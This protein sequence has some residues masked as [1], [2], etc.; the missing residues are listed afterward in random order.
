MRIGSLAAKFGFMIL[1]AQGV[2]AEAAEVKVLSALAMSPVMNE[3]GPQFERATGHN[4]VIQFDVA[5]LTTSLIDDLVKQGKIAAGTRAN[6]ARSGLGVIVRT[7][8]P[9]P[10]ISSA[11]AF[12][13]TMLDAKSISYGK[14]GATAIY[15]PGLFERLGIAEQMKSKTKHSGAQSVADGEAELGLI[16]ISAFQPVPGAELLGPFPPA[17][18][19]YVGYTG[20]VATAAKEADAGKALLNFLKATA[21]GPVLKAKGMEPI[22]P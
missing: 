18:Q 3:L 4:L 7:G 6:I 10:D 11:D 17:L 8:A 1:L 2:A 20:G 15:L 16:V 19:N 13:R 14:E 12:K 5:I 9:K 21:A 22:T